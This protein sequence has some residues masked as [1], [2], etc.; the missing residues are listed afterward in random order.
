MRVQHTYWVTMNYRT[1]SGGTLRR[2]AQVR[3]SSEERAVDALAH[4]IRRSV[5]GATPVTYTAVV[6]YA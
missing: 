5:L 2:K 3:A 1:V 6:T 4:Q